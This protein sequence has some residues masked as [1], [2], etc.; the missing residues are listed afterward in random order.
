AFLF[1]FFPD[2][3]L[4]ILAGLTDMPFRRYVLLVVLARPWGLLVACMV[5]SATVS[6][7]WWGMV[8][9]GFGGLALFLLAMRYGDRLEDA[10]M[11]RLEK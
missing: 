11:K 1:P 4:C 7:P 5:G 6:V 10:I 2:D 3:L 8:L 9:L